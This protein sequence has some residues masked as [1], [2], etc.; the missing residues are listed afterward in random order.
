MIVNCINNIDCK[1]NLYNKAKFQFA[2]AGLYQNIP[3]DSI[4]FGGNK[5]NCFKKITSKTLNMLY[6]T[7]FIPSKTNYGG[8][9]YKTFVLDRATHKPIEVL[10]KP[11]CIDEVSEEYNILDPKRG[12]QIIANRL[13]NYEEVNKFIISPGTMESDCPEYMGLGIRLHQIAIERMKMKK[14][15]NVEICSTTEA[16]P[17]HKKMGFEVINRYT[18]YYDKHNFERFVSENAE[19]LNLSEYAVKKL[20]VYTERVNDILLDIDKTNGNF[21]DYIYANNYNVDDIVQY[22]VLMRLS[23][24]AIAEWDKFIEKSPI[25]AN[26]KVPMYT[27]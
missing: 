11:D 1:I 14:L 8:Y 24:E 6:D 22:H 25:F 18:E 5:V 13:F 9:A 16:Y 21:L 23:P 19:N 10:V 7:K 4:C 15:Q 26:K 27:L 17:F 2:N 3:Q 20:M 12:M